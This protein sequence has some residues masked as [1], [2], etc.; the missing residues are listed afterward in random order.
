MAS[1][2][3]FCIARR[4]MGA[5]PGLSQAPSGAA[6]KPSTT[7]G[8]LARQFLNSCD[9]NENR[10]ALTDRRRSWTYRQLKSMALQFATV[11]Q[12]DPA[13]MGGEHV[14]ILIDNSPEYVVA[15]YGTI[16]AGSVAIPIPAGLSGSRLEQLLSLADV[17]IVVSAGD[18]LHGD[19]AKLQKFRCNPDQPDQYLPENNAVVDALAMMLFTSGSTGSP[20]AVMLSH[21]S[22]LANASSIKQF[23]PISHTDRTLAT[24][25]L[26]HALGN[27]VLQTHVLSGAEL[28]FTRASSFPHETI[29]SL[30]HYR[31]TSFSAVPEIFESIL[32]A[33]ENV[34]IDLPDL[35]YMAV[36]GGKMNAARAIEL[37]N[38]IAPA[39]FYLMYG[40]TEATARLA[41]LPPDLLATFPNTIGRAIPGVELAVLNEKRETCLPGETGTLHARGD[42]VMMGYW[43][44][45]E[46]T[47]SVL[48]NGWLHTGDLARLN[49][50]GLFEIQGRASGLVKIYGHRFHPQEVEQLLSQRQSTVQ[51]VA[52]P[53]SF[54][55]HTRLALFARPRDGRSLS[56][57]EIQSLCR[58]ALP[59]HMLPLRY[60][61]VEQWPVNAANKVDRKALIESIP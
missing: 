30:K 2:F 35:K 44:D 10:V 52:T 55:G 29:D 59:R 51:W 5:T 21:R 23:L 15:F 11:L 18:K 47:E 43:N 61:V 54:H 31:C 27:S 56:R 28:V 40:Q 48:H 17:E 3:Q 41:Y 60:E 53:M 12:A 36:A 16:L 25:P 34:A 37:Q 38:R 14:G 8:N 13:R 22:L 1:G 33:T 20:K 24:M 32:S 50:D 49:A 39:K 42:N 57:R 45:V 4:D 58:E 9:A 19:S 7:T 6:G 46:S 26:S